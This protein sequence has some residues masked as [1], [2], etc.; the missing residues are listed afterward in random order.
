LLKSH[1]NIY[2][3][4]F[5]LY[6]KI[7]PEM[8]HT[9]ILFYLLSAYLPCSFAQI[10]INE[11][12][13][14]APS[15][16][17][18]EFVELYNNTNQTIDLSDWYLSKGITFQ[19]SKG[20]T[21]RADEYIIIAQN[22]N[23]CRN[24]FKLPANNQIF[25]PYKGRLQSD[26]EKL[27]LHN[28][29]NI[30]V[31][32]ISYKLGFPYPITSPLDKISS[33]QLVHFNLD[34]LQPAAWRTASPSPCF[35]NTLVFA[36]DANIPPA[37]SEV[38]HYPTS[39]K[40]NEPVRIFAKITDEQGVERVELLYQTV[41]PGAYIR[42][43]DQAYENPLNWKSTLFYDHG[44]QGDSIAN[45]GIFTATIPHTEQ[46]HRRL[47][48]YRI[49][50]TDSTAKRIRVPYQDDTQPNFAYFVY[51]QLPD[52]AGY[53]FQKVQPV[54]VCHLIAKSEDV[55]YNINQYKGDSYKNTATV[56]YNGK[57]YDHIGFRSRGYN[58]R[59][60]RKKRN[61][62]FN[63]N[64][65]HKAEVLNNYHSPYPLKRDKW[66]LSGTWLLDKPNTHGLAE[67]ITYK[68][69]NLQ[70]APA[71]TADYIHLR[72]IKSTQ[73]QDSTNNDFYGL[74][75]VMENFDKDFLDNHNLPNGNIY[76][77]KPPKLRNQLPDTL[78][79]LSNEPYQQWDTLCDR[80]NT[81]QWWRKHLNLNAYF[82]FVNT[83]NA[84]NN[85]ETGYRK[86]HW[87]MEY[88][89]PKADNWFV[90]PWDMD[91]TWTST[92]GNSTISGSIKKA[93]FYHHSIQKD[94]D[95]ALR[96]FLDLLYNEQQMNTLIDEQA[97]FIYNPQAP[98]SFTDIDRAKWGQRYSSFNT[99]VINFKKFVRARRNYLLTT[100]PK[101]IPN[102]PTII[103]TGQDN[104]PADKLSFQCG[105]FVDDSSQFECL[106]WRIAEVSNFDNTF[107]QRNKPHSYEI[108]S[109][110]TS[111]E[112]KNFNTIIKIPAGIT[113]PA[114]SYRVRVR[115][116]N[117]RGYYSHWS[118]AVEFV[119]T[120]PSESF[121]NKIVISELL[122]HFNDSTKLEFLELKN[123]SDKVVD[124]YQFEFTEG[125]NFQFQDN[126]QI[127]TNGYAV[128]T[129]NLD[130]FKQTFGFSAQGEYK[131]S[132]SNEG[133]LIVLTDA[134]GFV[135]DSLRYQNGKEWDS[136]ANGTGFSLEYY[137]FDT[138]NYNANT[139][140]ASYLLGGTPTHDFSNTQQITQLN[141]NNNKDPLN[142][143]L[144]SLNVYIVSAAVATILIST[145][146]WLRAKYPKA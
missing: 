19:F 91:V 138:D 105:A 49:T 4:G 5:L 129:N 93:A 133:E 9:L 135:V 110:W 36:A 61:L 80:R 102:R 32:K 6:K 136:K 127:P 118:D 134:S 51:N 87:W 63:F 37:V 21:I 83:Q 17:F 76:A 31:D 56:V 88:H 10:I 85:R 123:I 23:Q 33:L 16:S 132:L 7:I 119:A 59:H 65:G 115:F 70:Q 22:P 12:H 131:G 95:N 101:S 46:I 52:Y 140:R 100:L 1:W 62:K 14:S 28:N 125:I 144:D 50:A 97:N 98:Y 71:T 99:E 25:G 114:H 121:A 13:C 30:L 74:Y 20:A 3:N 146:L 130:L 43:K 66:V 45:D 82:A 54:P 104:Y 48:R 58:N 47:I 84:I 124:L 15:G 67:L 81:E 137:N 77:Y 8:R 75:L 69:F 113:I 53:S 111:G 29:Q 79:G 94:Y 106:E 90:F 78:L 38:C 42:L 27:E 24:S 122:Y 117:K 2:S 109:N 35:Q 142:N 143:N 112:L 116:K 139:W 55:N 57:V 108:N 145:L 128:I 34:N 92:T 96:S 141:P 72:I 40:P 41:N 107:Y 120:A 86:Q 39:P 103:Y 11:I 18:S 44:K 64:R 60:A 68:L 126:Y 73:E 26:N 89:N